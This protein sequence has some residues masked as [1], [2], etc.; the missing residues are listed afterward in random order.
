MSSE[1]KI[2]PEEQKLRWLRYRTNYKNKNKDNKIYCDTCQMYAS[3]IEF[4]KHVKS[5]KHTENSKEKVFNALPPI[6]VFEKLSVENKELCIFN[7]IETYDDVDPDNLIR[8]SLIESLTTEYNNI[9]R[10][11][12]EMCDDSES[13]ED[14][15]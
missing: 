12:F 5:K 9:Y 14:S 13:E 7:I 2:T 4:R 15:N 10:N 3:K 1:N 11:L 6:E 8:D